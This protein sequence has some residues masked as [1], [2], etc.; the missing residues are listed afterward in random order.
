MVNIYNFH[1]TFGVGK[2]WV[3][4]QTS[5][6]SKKLRLVDVLH[7]GR[8]IITYEC[9]R[10]IAVL[11][12][13]LSSLG[14]GGSMGSIPMSDRTVFMYSELVIVHARKCIWFM[15]S[16]KIWKIKSPHAIPFLKS[17]FQVQRTM[18]ELLNQLDGFEATKNIK[19]SNKEHRSKE[20]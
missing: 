14:S 17:V 18:L 6:L 2:S 9:P 19:V 20:Q 5:N 13:R 8:K 3:S 11:T 4:A 7:K 15:I 12:E 10:L 16:S 1:E